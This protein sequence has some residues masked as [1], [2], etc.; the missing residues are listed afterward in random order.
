MYLGN[1]LGRRKKVKK[2]HKLR[3]G[4]AVGAR[5]MIDHEYDHAVESI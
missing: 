2:S 5:N 3:F 4:L 1:G